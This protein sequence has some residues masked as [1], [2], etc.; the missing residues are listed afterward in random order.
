MKKPWT[1]I[2][3]KAEYREKVYSVSGDLTSLIQGLGPEAIP[4]QKCYM[5]MGSVLKSWK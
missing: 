4:S 2:G 5:K 1:G 3:Q